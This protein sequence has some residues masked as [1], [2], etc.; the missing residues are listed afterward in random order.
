MQLHHNPPRR[1]MDELAS[2]TGYASTAILPMRE[3]WRQVI[4][5]QI[6]A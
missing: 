6:G 4:F 2:T 3:A 1:L 5:R